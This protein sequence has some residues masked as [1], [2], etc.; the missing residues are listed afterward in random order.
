MVNLRDIVFL[1]KQPMTTMEYV[2]SSILMPQSTTRSS[3]A[4]TSSNSPGIS[5][6]GF[7]E[8]VIHLEWMMVMMMTGS[9][10]PSTL[11]RLETPGSKTRSHTV[12]MEDS[13]QDA[14]LRRFTIS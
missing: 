4:G 7:S 12:S 1:T 6:T 13:T 2:K 8:D 9:M 5:G 11:S 10:S 14:T 3:A